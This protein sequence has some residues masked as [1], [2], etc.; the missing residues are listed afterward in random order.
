MAPNIMHI[1]SYLRN[2]QLSEKLHCMVLSME[3]FLTSKNGLLL[4]ASIVNS[5]QNATNLVLL[6]LTLSARNKRL[7]KKCQPHSARR[8]LHVRLI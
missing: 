7:I 8:L 5:K 1:N 2:L 6:F 4:H 3:I